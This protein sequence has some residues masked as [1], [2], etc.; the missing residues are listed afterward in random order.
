MQDT[1]ERLIPEGNTKTLT[2][3]EHL[4]RYTSVLESVKGKVV[5]DIASGAGYGTNLIATSA[6]SVFGVDYS[7]DAIKYAKNLYK[8]KNLK[9]IQGDAQKLP[10]EDNT[11]DVVVS[12]ETIEHLKNPEAFVKEVKRVLKKNGQFIVSTPNDDEYIEGNEFHLH[13]FN[14]NELKR[15]I[16]KYFKN[17]EFYYQGSYFSAG[18]YSK[19]MFEVGG[20]APGEFIKTF[21]QPINKSIYFIAS[22]SNSDVAKLSETTVVA[23]SWN[24]KDDLAADKARRIDRDKLDNA[25]RHAQDKVTELVLAKQAVEIDRDSLRNELHAIKGS[26]VWR[27]TYRVYKKAKRLVK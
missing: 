3:G 1:G 9:F 7:E 11:I 22:A 19:K 6:Q 5:L 14:L 13:E 23:D 18:V 21:G 17:V 8:A 27:V 10:L 25:L 2:Y 12:L 20:E 16:K 4:A 24:T 15:L 26:K